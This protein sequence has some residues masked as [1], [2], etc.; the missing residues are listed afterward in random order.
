MPK[1]SFFCISSGSARSALEASSFQSEK[2]ASRRSSLRVCL[3]SGEI[4]SLSL[5]GATRSGKVDC[6]DGLCDGG[7]CAGQ[8]NCDDGGAATMLDA[9][10]VVS[11]SVED[12][13]RSRKKVS[14]SSLDW[15]SDWPA[16]WSTVCPLDWRDCV[17]AGAGPPRD[18]SDCAVA[19]SAEG[20]LT[21]LSAGTSPLSTQG[22]MQGFAKAPS[23][24]ARPWAIAGGGPVRAVWV[25]ERAVMKGSRIGRWVVATLFGL[26]HRRLSVDNH[27][28][29]RATL[30]RASLGA[31]LMYKMCSPAS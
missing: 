31:R 16:G 8:K 28:S 30:A 4:S 14:K 11:P 24:R 3:F 17:A 6:L 7:G 29:S 15:W 10:T 19:I 25:E 5:T 21:S 23:R 12:A 13:E 20:F 1:G 18:P 27:S 26:K 2:K 22:G 9:A